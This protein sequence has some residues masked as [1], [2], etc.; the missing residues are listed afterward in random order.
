MCFRAS[1]KTLLTTSSVVWPSRT[2]VSICSRYI[3]FSF[4]R[5]I[6]L[7]QSRQI[8]RRIFRINLA[9]PTWMTGAIRS[10]WPK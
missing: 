2:R 9:N 6:S 3:R 10:M 8:A 4:S 5:S 1:A 7:E